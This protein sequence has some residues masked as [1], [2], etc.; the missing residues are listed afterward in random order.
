MN[1]RISARVIAWIVAFTSAFATSPLTTLEY[2]VAGRLLDVTPA[3]LSVPK[4]IAGSISAQLSG[5]LAAPAG[6]FLEA[7]LRGPSFP[8]RRLVGEP[9]KPLLLPPLNL[10]GDYSLDGIRLID[11][12]SGATLFEGMPAACR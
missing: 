7:T 8:A 3:V 11:G 9:N 12:T 5:G 1:A 10:V 4:G 6:S 2:K